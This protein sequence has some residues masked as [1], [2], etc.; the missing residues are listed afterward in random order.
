[1]IRDCSNFTGLDSEYFRVSLQEGER[2]E[3]CL[4]ALAEILRG[5]P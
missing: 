3:R 1:M 5:K 2:N 4:A